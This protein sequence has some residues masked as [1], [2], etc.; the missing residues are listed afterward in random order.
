MWRAL[1]LPARGVQAS[2]IIP[3]K[4]EAVNLP[5]TLA[6]LAAQTDLHGQAL[7]PHSF[8]VLVLANNCLDH[9]AHVVREFAARH[10]RLRLHI[11][12]VTLPKEQAHVGQARRLLMD[13]AC[14]RLE[15]GG[16]PR[17]FIASTDADTR[18]SPT[19]LI[20][21]AAELATGVDAVGG[22]ILM[23]NADPTCPVRRCQLRDAAYYLLRARLEDHLDP[24]PYDPWPRHHQHFG[25]NLALTTRAYRHVGGL[26]VVPYLEDEALVQRLVHHDLHLRHSPAVK[27]YTSGRQQG[28][29]AVG[30]SWQLRQWAE[31]QQAQREPLVDNPQRLQAE[32]Q[33]R[34][35]LRRLW[36]QH[37]AGTLRALPAYPTATGLSR[38][39]LRREITRAGS[40]GQL[41]E[42]IRG[43]FLVQCCGCW[44]AVPL[45]VAIRMLRE[46]VAA[47]ESSPPVAAGHLCI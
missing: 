8:E 10:P 11:A 35:Q 43:R 3:A 13:E 34:A 2:V 17:A 32:W 5:A 20:S 15:Q 38:A 12:E 37:S 44:P 18:V 30:L 7:L 25:A 46:Q 9:T 47:L 4:D 41:W 29:V 31:L 27:V 22:R 28:R 26:P 1:P 40:F 23:D 14:R 24:A 45:S 6:A 33:L 19:W 16:H 36:K 42:K 21:I 39:A